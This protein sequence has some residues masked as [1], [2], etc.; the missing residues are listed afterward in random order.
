MTSAP[1]T[2]PTSPARSAPRAVADI[3]PT[4]T[5]PFDP[6]ADQ[7][8]DTQP[9]HNRG[10]RA[11][12]V[13]VFIVLS[14]TLV[15]ATS[16]GIWV[17]N[18]VLDTDD[19]VAA[20]GTLPDDPRVADAVSGFVAAEVISVT[21]AESEIENAL[22]PIV[23]DDADLLGP[24]I[25][26]AVEDVVRNAADEVIQTEEFQE[27]W[28]EV[29]RIA[30]EEAVLLIRGDGDAIT[31]A[32]GTVQLNLL[33]I[34]NGVITEVAADASKL[35]GTNID[36]PQLSESDLQVPAEARQELETVLG[37]E[38]PDDFGV[39]TVYQDNR[40]AEVQR[41]I[42]WTDDL[43]IG[44][45]IG[46]IVALV[47]AIGFS[48]T[49]RRTIAMIGIGIAIVATGL[50]IAADIIE[51]DIVGHISDPSARQATDAAIDVAL[52]RGLEGHLGWTVAISLLVAIG[53]WLSGPGRIQTVSASAA[54]HAGALQGAGVG[55][56]FLILISVDRLTWSEFFAVA[57]L[58]GG[59]VAIVR[60]L[61][62]NATPEE[63]EAN[64]IDLT[65]SPEPSQTS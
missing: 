14:A 19:W 51:N 34:V 61:A 53:A 16:G 4:R 30:H 7:T 28:E 18:T 45:G 64:E 1:P 47:A 35:F 49:R 40:L 5:E 21:N 43:L 3:E 36:I 11:F 48:K 2:E 22:Q 6:A 33:P 20:V 46:S 15:A 24:P 52:L 23:G 55:V 65:S 37:V 54:R 12:V 57:I 62:D 8:A 39:V 38:L 58:T 10:G 9:T 29:N 26:A 32:D 25:T 31:S 50:Y 42:R 27:V 60:V 41:T 44:A 13:G 56:A 59:W 63:T 17:R